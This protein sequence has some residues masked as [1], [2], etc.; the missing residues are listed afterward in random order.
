MSDFMEN[1]GFK[2]R[3]MMWTIIGTLLFI[4]LCVYVYKQSFIDIAPV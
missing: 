3:F 4:A 2:G 1:R